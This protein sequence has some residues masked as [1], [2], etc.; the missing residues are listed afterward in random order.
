MAFA[1]LRLDSLSEFLDSPNGLYR[2]HGNNDPDTLN[3]RILAFIDTERCV[4]DASFKR[5]KNDVTNIYDRNWKKYDKPTA[6]KKTNDE[7]VEMLHELKRTYD[8][9]RGKIIKVYPDIV[10]KSHDFLKLETVTLSDM[11]DSLHKARKYKEWMYDQYIDI[12]GRYK[13]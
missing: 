7:V 1:T 12:V 8:M 3:T 9:Y 10:L 6:M 5:A 13:C 11:Y 4:T 2:K